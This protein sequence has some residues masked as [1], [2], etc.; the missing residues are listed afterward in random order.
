MAEVVLVHGIGPEG[1]TEEELTTAWTTTLAHTLREHGYARHADRMDTGATSV[2]MAYYRDLFS[3][4]APKDDLDVPFPE[5]MALAAEMTGEDIMDNIRRNASDPAERD[6]AARELDWLRAEVGP[7]Q[8]PFE[9]VRLVVSMLGR[10]GPV[11]R[12]GFATLSRY[13]IFHLGQVAAYLDDETVRERA[14]ESV[15]SQV[16]P[17]TRAVVAHSLGTVVAYEALHRL[18]QPLPLLLTF[19]S[20][21]GMRSIVHK[22]LRPLPMH[23]P[24]QVKRWVNVADRDDFVVSTLKLRNLLPETDDVLEPTVLVKNSNTDPHAATEYLRHRETIEPLAGVL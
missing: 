10:L 7:E 9:P 21:L 23:S 12:S 15:L 20:P 3:R 19:G 22:R 18:D 11:A 4:Y 8:G 16:T 24:A 14:I 5:D 2:A 17:H 13:G 1:Q 6:E